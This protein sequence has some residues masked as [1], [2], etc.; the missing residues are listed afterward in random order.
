M[1]RTWRPLLTFP[2]SD[3]PAP[4]RL[5][6]VYRGRKHDVRV[7]LED[8]NDAIMD[9][10]RALEAG[11]QAGGDIREAARLRDV[12]AGCICGWRYYY[13]AVSGG[14]F[15]RTRLGAGCPWHTRESRRR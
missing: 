7:D 6:Y 10:R 13:G 8:A 9:D 12:P 5:S 14:R 1:T 3:I 2:D 11:R 4:G 15:K